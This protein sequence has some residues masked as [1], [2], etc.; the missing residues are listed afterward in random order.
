M[1]GGEGNSVRLQSPQTQNSQTE[2]ST[3]CDHPAWLEDLCSKKEQNSRREN[4]RTLTFASLDANAVGEALRKMDLTGKTVSRGPTRTITGTV[5][6]EE[7]LPA[8]STQE[9][10]DEVITEMERLDLNETKQW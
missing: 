10:A 4:L 2:P 9:S 5:D 7:K 1:Q 6:I 3:K 8:E